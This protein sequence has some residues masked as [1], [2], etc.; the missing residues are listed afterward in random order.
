MISGT[1]LRALAISLSSNSVVPHHAKPLPF[2]RL[3]SRQ[4][5]IMERGRERLDGLGISGPSMVSSH[6]T[7]RICSMTKTTTGNCPKSQNRLR[8]VQRLPGNDLEKTCS[9]ACT[10]VIS[11]IRLLVICHLRILHSL[12]VERDP[13]TEGARRVGR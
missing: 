13:Y 8:D 1:F 12:Q 6:L 7:L 5:R 11:P 4:R 10:N 9:P 2:S 3:L